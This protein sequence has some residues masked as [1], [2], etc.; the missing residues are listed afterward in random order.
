MSIRY[1]IETIKDS[2]GGRLF[3]EGQKSFQLGLSGGTKT[4][5]IITYIEKSGLAKFTFLAPDRPAIPS[6]NVIH[7]SFTSVETYD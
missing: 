2:L 4:A 7:A 6:N 1:N 3:P 5:I